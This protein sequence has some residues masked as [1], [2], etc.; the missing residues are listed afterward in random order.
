MRDV[1]GACYEAAMTPA[2][3]PPPAARWTGAF[4]SLVGLLMFLGFGGALAS[5]VVDTLGAPAEPPHVAPAA[6][7]TEV[8][9]GATWVAVDDASEPCAYPTIPSGASTASYR[10]LASPGGAPIGLAELSDARPCSDPPSTV[11]GTARLRTLVDLELPPDATAFLRARLGDE[12]VVLWV[13]DS[14]RLGLSEAAMWSA[15]AA[16]GLCIAW[17]YAAAFRARRA[18]P[19]LPALPT[20]PALPLLPS[21]PLRLAPAYRASPLLGIAFFAACALMFAAI[22]AST[23]PADGAPLDG[24]TIALVA[25]GGVMTGVFVLLLVVVVR[26]AVRAPRVV[27]GLR[28]AWAEVS[29][30]EAALAK[31]V[32]VGNRAI[33]YRDPFSDPREPERTI[34]LVVGANEGMPWIVEG[35]VLVLAREGDAVRHVLREDG[36]PFELSDDELGAAIR[37][38]RPR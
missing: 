9:A 27:T 6:L 37:A 28:E 4:F 38:A 26:A 24:E 14:P 18:E 23:L 19:R 33:A 10:I 16:L 7:T 13:G 35:H 17:F 22:T 15:M 25:F 32:D 1:L 5:R 29:S 12:V 3:S 30:H 31:G 20:R 36:G 2:D 21:R 34:E 8:R 11:T